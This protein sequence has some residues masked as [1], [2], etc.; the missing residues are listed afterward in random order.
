MEIVINHIETQRLKLINC[1]LQIL[2][3]IFEG[4]Q[5][6]ANA[7][8]ISVSDNWA[9]FGEQPFRYTDNK[10][11]DFPE[12][13]I[14]WTYLILHK[15]NNTLIGSCGYKGK[16]DENGMIELGYEIKVAYR[17][18]GLATE[19]AKALIENAFKNENVKIAS[20]HTLAEENASVKVLRKCGLQFVDEIFDK[21]DGNLWFWKLNKLV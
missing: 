15:K 4:N 5:A 12:D 21:E 9:T 7:L 11:K 18:K 20:A 19:A 3:V 17:N 16:P 14:W 13:A 2:N 10:L 1:N 6:L 8:Q